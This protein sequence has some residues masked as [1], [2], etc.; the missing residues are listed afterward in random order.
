MDFVLLIILTGVLGLALGTQLSRQPPQVTVIQVQPEERYQAGG[1]CAP[2]LIAIVLFL[3]LAW[4]VGS[5]S[6]A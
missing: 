1:G 3:F 2:V 4:F 6:P 5:I